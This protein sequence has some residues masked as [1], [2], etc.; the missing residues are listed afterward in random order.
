M[1]PYGTG[2]ITKTASGI[3]AATL[4]GRGPSVYHVR[5]AD[6]GW[7]LEQEGSDDAL[8][9]HRIKRQAVKAGRRQADESQPSRLV[10][11]RRDDT[12][13]AEHEYGFE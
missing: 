4:K 5:K 9:S 10:I 13:Q 1:K 6:D 11:H 2:G 12:I 8:S 3:A 7:I